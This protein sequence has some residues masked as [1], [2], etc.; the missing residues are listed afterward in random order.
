MTHVYPYWKNANAKFIWFLIIIK[1]WVPLSAYNCTGTHSIANSASISPTSGGFTGLDF[2]VIC[3]IGYSLN[4]GN[5]TMI[6]NGNIWNNKPVC[7]GEII[8]HILIFHCAV[9]MTRTHFN[10][11]RSNF[12][13]FFFH[14]ALDLAVYRAL[15]NNYY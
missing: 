8:I 10:H 7:Q 12:Y 2:K 14:K 9:F 5:G 4:P 11:L 13:M 3:N 6:C 15:W 1:R